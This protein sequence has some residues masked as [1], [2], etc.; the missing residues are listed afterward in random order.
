M[1]SSD[2]FILFQLEWI[3]YKY[4][5]RPDRKPSSGQLFSSSTV[6]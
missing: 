3:V 4:F 1:H 5:S 2:Y 6:K